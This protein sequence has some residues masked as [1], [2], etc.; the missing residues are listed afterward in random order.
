MPHGA[1]GDGAVGSHT[2]GKVKGHACTHANLHA[3]MIPLLSNGRPAP[4]NTRDKH[5]KPDLHDEDPEGPKQDDRGVEPIV[6][7][8][9]RGG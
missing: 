6:R 7:R 9:D 5:G 4:D 8:L 2:H 1:C 3:L